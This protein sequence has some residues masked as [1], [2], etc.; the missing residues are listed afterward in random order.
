MFQLVILISLPYL[1]LAETDSDFP[2]YFGSATLSQ[3]LVPPPGLLFVTF[4]QRKPL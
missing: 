1:L 3:A 4:F 2:L